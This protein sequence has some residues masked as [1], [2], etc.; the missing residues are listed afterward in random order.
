MVSLSSTPYIHLCQVFQP[1]ESTIDTSILEK[2][3][4]FLKS[5]IKG[6]AFYGKLLNVNATHIRATCVSKAVIDCAEKDHS[7]VIILGASREGLL[8][9][10]I[11]GN[12]PENISRLSN[13]NVILVRSA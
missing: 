5:K 10:T 3:V 1:D 9:Q 4:R 6:N 13:R 7:D 12:I 11:K 8:Q 2:S